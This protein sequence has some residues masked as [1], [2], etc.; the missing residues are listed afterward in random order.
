L[1]AI[2]GSEVSKLVYVR[3]TGTGLTQT[4]TGGHLLGTSFAPEAPTSKG[5]DKVTF[6]LEE[7]TDAINSG[8]DTFTEFMAKKGVTNLT[9][10]SVDSDVYKAWQTEYNKLPKNY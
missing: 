7:I 10:V 4:L 2:Y 9:T 6:T 1:H 5:G 3:S 8:N